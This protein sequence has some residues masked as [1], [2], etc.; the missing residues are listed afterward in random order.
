MAGHFHCIG[1]QICGDT[2]S[3]VYDSQE[4]SLCVRSP[5][6]HESFARRT[7]FDDGHLY[8][9]KSAIVVYLCM[10][11]PT[12]GTKNAIVGMVSVNTHSKRVHVRSTDT[13][14]PGRYA[15]TPT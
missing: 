12:Y 2:L 11:R 7:H 1:P 6:A 5:E 8:Q 13:M 15:F 10:L 14:S 9:Q 4:S 3:A